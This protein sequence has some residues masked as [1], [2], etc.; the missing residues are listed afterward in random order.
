MR[1]PGKGERFL[2]TAGKAIRQTGPVF[3]LKF[4]VIDNIP[5]FSSLI[6]RAAFF[7]TPLKLD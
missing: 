1:R 7:S 2:H 3:R 5:D 6:V 4:D